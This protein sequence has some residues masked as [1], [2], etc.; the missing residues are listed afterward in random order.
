MEELQELVGQVNR[1]L[2]KAQD[3][4]LS[5]HGVTYENIEDVGCI[6]DDLILLQNQIQSQTDSLAPSELININ[7]PWTDGRY[8]PLTFWMSYYNI[9]VARIQKA[10][11]DYAEHI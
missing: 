3:S 6:C 10:I 2:I 9:A 5:N 8:F 11:N 4:L 7:V 1:C